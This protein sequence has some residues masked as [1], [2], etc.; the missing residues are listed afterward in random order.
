MVTTLP[1]SPRTRISAMSCSAPKTFVPV[2][3]PHLRPRTD[4][5]HQIVAMLAA[6]GTDIM[7]SM[8]PGW[9]E[10]STRGRP[11]PSMR[12]LR[13]AVRLRSPL[14]KNSK[15]TEFSGSTTQSFVVPNSAG[16]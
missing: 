9:K 3:P 6:S 15:K 8:T 7:R 10:G 14:R 11:M 4:C 5:S 1:V 13:S 12:E 2:D 16:R